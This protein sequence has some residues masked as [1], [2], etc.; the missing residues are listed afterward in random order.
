VLASLLPAGS[1]SW[2]YYSDRLTELPLGVF[3][4]AIAT[5][6]LP[7]LSSQQATADADAGSAAFAST[8]HW[9]L[10][11]V[12]LIALPATVALLLLAEPIL[13]TLFH[14][15]AFSEVDVD[16]AS[17]SLRAYSLG[18]CAFMLIKVLA[19]GFYA[20]QDMKT[21]V[22]IGIKAMVANMVLNPVFIFPLMWGFNLGHVGLALATSASAWLNAALLYRGLRQQGWLKPDGGA[23]SFWPRLMAALALM[24]AVIIAF[25]PALGWWLAQGA[26]IR[27]AA[28]GGIV[29]A[30]CAVYLATLVLLGLRWQDLR[31]PS[32]H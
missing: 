8:L 14:Y 21:P 18:L 11:L 1:V 6:I 5:V 9:A 17:Y 12:L 3:A 26:V 22:R 19:P 16:Q 24:V 29:F 32:V 23:A 20:R 27:G 13:V 30:G 25:T 10:R 15:G 31:G 2:L 4:I 28:M 7:A